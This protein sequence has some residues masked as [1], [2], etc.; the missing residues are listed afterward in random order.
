MIG[1]LKGI[2]AAL[3]EDRALIEVQGV[4]YLVHAGARTLGRLVVGAPAH[5][6]VETQVR[7]DS[8]RLFGF[9]TDGER[10]WFARLQE[11]P[12]VGAK[13]ALAIL[14]TLSPHD[15]MQAAALEDRASVARANGVGPKLAA[16]IV[17]ELKG[18]AAP[19]G[20]VA[21]AGA[22]G[23]SGAFT[24]PSAAPASEEARREGLGDMA[25]R[26]QA[27]SAL[28]NLGIAQPEALRAVGAAYAGF[29]EDPALGVLV[30]AALKEL[31][32]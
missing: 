19:T 28:V 17:T 32:R 31:G 3:A 12:G 2:V 8:M 5:V 30:K 16:R 27:I 24:A 25:L 10:A 26:N 1:S 15:L 4:G 22:T 14:D 20:M 13:V 9:S 21:S 29:D 7:E 18:R 6:W 11:I 23:A